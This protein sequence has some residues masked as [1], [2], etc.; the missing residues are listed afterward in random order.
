MELPLDFNQTEQ[1]VDHVHDRKKDFYHRMQF[2][3]PRN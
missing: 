1:A 3:F 2:H